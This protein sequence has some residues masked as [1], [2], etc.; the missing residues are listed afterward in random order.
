M[1][2][3]I[4]IYPGRFQPMGKHHYE[5]Y[6][7]ACR[8]Y[9]EDNVFIT[10]SGKVQ[11]GRSPLTFEQKSNI[12]NL[13]G[14]PFSNI[15]QSKNPYAPKE[16]FESKGIKLESVKLVVIV[17]NKDMQ[18]N[19]RFANLGMTKP[20]KRNPV[21][22]PTYFQ[23]LNESSNKTA[24]IHG[25]IDV[26]PHISHILPNG[27]ESSGTALREFLHKAS[28]NQFVEAMGFYDKNS[29]ALLKKKDMIYEKFAK[30]E[31]NTVKYSKHLEE[32]LNELDE[33]KKSFN[34]RKKT[35][36]RYRKE[37]ATIQNAINV[38]RKMKRDNNKMLDSNKL[39]FTDKQLKEYYSKF[40]K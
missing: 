31:K 39:K 24:D 38:I 10:T 27:K 25:Y 19:P 28:F 7:W 16:L 20:T 18:E 26:A 29:D 17:G 14:V 8:K 23:A 3:T 4:A 6:L 36:Q 1:K 37:A 9:G 33:I 30:L 5:T 40:I 35:G 15:I 11:E 13:H 21:P 34:S 12:I 22:R 32:I 2:R